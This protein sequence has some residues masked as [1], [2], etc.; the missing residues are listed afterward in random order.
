MVCHIKKAKSNCIPIQMN[1]DIPII[2]KLTGKRCWATVE[3]KDGQLT[4]KR[5][6]TIVLKLNGV[7]STIVGVM[8]KALAG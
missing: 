1:I 5:K 6:V 2:S 4:Q 7:D 3:R 8:S